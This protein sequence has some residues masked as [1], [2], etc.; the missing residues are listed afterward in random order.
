MA[1]FADIQIRFNADLKEFSSQMQNAQR[2]LQRTGRQL[3]NVGA[4]LTLAVT[5]PLLGLGA[6]AVN[7]AAD[8]ETLNATLET[9]F[10]GNE[11]AAKDA[12]NQITEFTAKTPFQ[13]EEVADGFIKLKNLGLDPSI[14]S[15]RSYGNTAS[16]LG[17]DLNQFIEAVADASVNEFE[18]LKEFG[19]KAKQEGES[20]AFTFQGVTTS[21]AKNGEDIQRYL[22]E[23]GNT[24]FAGGIEKQANTFK[25]IISTLKDNF[26]LLLADFGEPL[27]E[28]LKPLA[29]SVSEIGAR[30]RELSPE[31]KKFIVILG[32]I[33]AAVGPLLA[34]AGTIL[35]AIGTGLALLTGPIGLV[36]AGVTAIG[37]AIYKNWEPIKA[38]LVEIADYFIDLYN[39]SEVFRIGVEAI[40]AGFQTL[41]E[42]GRFTFT[43]LG[44]LFEAS[45]RQ[46]KEGFKPLGD[47]FRAILLGPEGL[48]L[49]PAILADA[50]D[51]GLGNAKDLFAEL[52]NDLSTLKTNVEISIKQAAFNALS[53]TKK[54]EKFSAAIAE[55]VKDGIE[56]GAEDLDKKPPPVD[57]TPQTKK[58]QIDSPGITQL[59]SLDFTSS[60]A[61][62]FQAEPLN[63]KL[64]VFTERLAEFR[65]QSAEILADVAANFVTGFADIIGGIAA[66]TAGL[67]DIGAL[68]L[69]TM[70]ELA[71]QLGK[72]AI[73]I[74]I[75]MK[76]LKLAF[77]SPGAAILAG[78]GLVALGALLKGVAKN[79]AGN[80]SSGGIV[81]GGFFSGDKLLAGVNS[82]ELILNLAQQKNLATALSAR[83]PVILQPSLAYDGRK[84]RV[85]LN[86]VDNLNSR[87][88]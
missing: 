41:Y 4:G 55:S 13:L 60:L 30:F 33:A 46:F 26:K 70:G 64:L 69:N 40:R 50:F 49:I 80:F 76:A 34:L 22:Q 23:I 77:K 20:V 48:K 2:S 39:E 27:L 67:D 3:Q 47:L 37:V 72:S 74:G 82:G 11:K 62:T 29:Q 83:S 71:Q 1:S 52:E 75:T 42:V 73:Q 56:K 87:T 7:A 79:F 59:G 84:L 38:T 53:G 10:Q 17:K 9:V 54:Y 43:A 68:L 36:I 66:G 81:G 44:R 6:L 57:G 8:F 24:T 5:T 45:A 32:G 85:M 86:Q 58:L 35:P 31:T 15:L 28:I 12:F 88:S 65:E 51:Q 25:G 18:R 19:I 21:V 16:A 14:A 63:D 61:D 78:A